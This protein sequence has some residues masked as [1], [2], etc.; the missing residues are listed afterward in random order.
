[1]R[2]MFCCRCCPAIEYAGTSRHSP[3]HPV[4]SEDST[5]QDGI[6]CAPALLG[7]CLS[8]A[9][10]RKITKSKLKGAETPLVALPQRKI[11]SHLFHTFFFFL[12]VN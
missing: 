11:Q 3:K 4:L 8:T 6:F 2:K 5:R 7:L 1:M 9:A 12:K 10:S